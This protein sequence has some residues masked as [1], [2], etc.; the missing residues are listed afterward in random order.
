MTTKELKEIERA[1]LIWEDTIKEGDVIAK[2]GVSQEVLR[3]M[4]REGKIKN[5][6]YI[7][8]STTGNPLRPG[9]KPVY[10]LIELVQIFSPAT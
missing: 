6:R 9:R 7:T 5:F 1:R 10:S 3:K 8:P 2:L 4:R